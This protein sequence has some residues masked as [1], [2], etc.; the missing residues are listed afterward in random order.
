MV[1]IRI[2]IETHAQK[3][4]NGLQLLMRVPAYTGT[5]AVPVYAGTRVRGYRTGTRVCGYPRV[6]IPA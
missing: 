6:R 1:R 5:R 2:P 3:Q 4:S